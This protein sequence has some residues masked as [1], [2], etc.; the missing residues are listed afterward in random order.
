MVQLF[1]DQPL[2]LVRRLA[3][4]GLNAGVGKQTGSID[5]GLCKEKPPAE[6]LRRQKVLVRF[7][8]APGARACMEIVFSHPQLY[9]SVGWRTIFGRL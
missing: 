9:H 7:C 8:A 6:I 1:K 2:Q 3:L 5:L 4:P